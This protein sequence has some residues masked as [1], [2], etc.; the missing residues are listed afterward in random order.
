MEQKQEVFELRNIDLEDVEDLLV[1]VEASFNLKF[2]RAEFIHVTT[3]GE[4]CAA[5][6]NKIQ[7]ED[8]AGCTSQQAFYKLKAALIK[9]IKVEE[10]KVLPSSLL[11]DFFPRKGRRKL[12]HQMYKNLGFEVNLLGPPG[13]LIISLLL[14]IVGFLI[15]FFW[16]WKIGSLGLLGTI[17]G[18]WIANKLGSELNSNTI[19]ELVTQMSR[20][21]Y[22]KSRRNSKTVNRKEI[23]GTLISWFK[24][25]LFL[26]KLDRSST[27]K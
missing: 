16:S 25:D 18:F 5:I 23:E 13:W 22:L 24:D 27:F 1:K 17:A 19:A 9:T 7:L 26:D 14:C 3:F 12:V 6:I 4:L 8:A 10:S 20:E 2:E 21:N 15:S 11:S